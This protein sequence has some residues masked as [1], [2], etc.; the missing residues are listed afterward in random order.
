[1][2]SG[3]KIKS[4]DVSE[5]LSNVDTKG[6]SSSPRW[7]TPAATAGV[8]MGAER[9]SGKEWEKEEMGFGKSSF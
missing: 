4:I 3:N 8:D 7:N 6:V 1:M 2:G 5:L 9:V